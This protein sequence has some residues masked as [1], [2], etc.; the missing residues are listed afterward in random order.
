M[1][2]DL[3]ALV[4]PGHTALV[5]QEVQRAVIGEHSPLPELAEAARHAVPKI[6]A[7][8]TSARA[9][10]LSVIHCTAERR[11][12]GRGANANARIFRYMAKSE[13]PLLQGSEAAAI[14]PEISVADSDIVM[15]R[16]HGLSPFQGTELDFVLRNLGVEYILTMGIVTDQ[17]V[18]TAIRDGCARGFLMTIIDDACATH[19]QERHDASTRAIK[20][21]CRKRSTD[22]VIAELTAREA[23]R[24][25]A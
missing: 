10:G 1:A 20:G 11:A 14:V 8:V 22:E 9:A 12:D 24:D 13:H 3:A 4:S 2:L 17:C 25:V 7:L 15:P 18:E 6:A 5:T 23:A 16:L 21:Y 19:S